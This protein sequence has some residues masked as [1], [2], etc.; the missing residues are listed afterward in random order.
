MKIEEIKQIDYE[1]N[2]N[3]QQGQ[4][5]KYNSKIDKKRLE[6]DGKQQDV[7]IIATCMNLIGFKVLKSDTK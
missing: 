5:M 6:R 2:Q 3:Y 4:H 7:I 1:E